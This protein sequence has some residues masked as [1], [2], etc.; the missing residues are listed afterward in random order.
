MPGNWTGSTRPRSSTGLTVQAGPHPNWYPTGIRITDTGLD[1]VPLHPH[2]FHGEWNHTITAQSDLAGALTAREATR[3]GR[4]EWKRRRVLG[5][6][7]LMAPI[8][9]FHWASLSGGS[10]LG[11]RPRRHAWQR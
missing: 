1:A 6:L 2:D 5:T 4:R 10:R 8:P 9:S 7:R 11:K 3:P